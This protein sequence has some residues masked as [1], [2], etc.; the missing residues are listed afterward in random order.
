MATYVQ[1]QEWVA[2]H[3]GFVPKTCWIADIK[4]KSGL[5]MRKAPNRKSANRVYPC[6]SEKES[7]IFA[8]LKHFGM[9]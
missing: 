3:Y 2:Q 5:S 9:I 6:P 7:A 4:G 8:A 1:I